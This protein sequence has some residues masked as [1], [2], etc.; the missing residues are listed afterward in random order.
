MYMLFCHRRNIWKCCFLKLYRTEYRIGFFYILW[1]LSVRRSVCLLLGITFLLKFCD[2]FLSSSSL[3]LSGIS[4][5][6]MLD[7]FGW[8][9][10]SFN[11][12]QVFLIPWWLPFWGKIFMFPRKISYF[13]LFL[14]LSLSLFGLFPE[15]CMF[16][17]LGLKSFRFC[18]CFAVQSWSF[19]FLLLFFYIAVFYWYFV[20]GLD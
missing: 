17:S 20:T 7:L 14:C 5:N 12:Q 8:S 10:A 3:S 13:S 1:A 4:L 19:I 15:L 6:W 16:A 2:F 18:C 9:S 11:F